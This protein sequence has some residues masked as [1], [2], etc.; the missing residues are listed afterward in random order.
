MYV[1]I[2]K[3]NEIP[4]YV[5]M[6]KSVGRANPLN[7]GGRGWLC[8]QTLEK[9][10]RNNVISEIHI[11][12]TVEEA[13]ALEIKL[14]EEFG[15]IQ[16]GTGPLTNLRAGGDGAHGMS[17]EGRERTRQRMLTNNP[18]K[19]EQVRK[20]LSARNSTPEALEKMTGGNNPAKQPAARKK[21]TALWQDPE[22]KER[23][24]K[25]RTGVQKHSAEEKE[26]RRQ[27]LLDPN[28]PMREYHKTLNTD[29]DIKAKRV[30][31]LRTREV[32]AK[33]SASLKAAWARRKGVII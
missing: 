4:F 16:L 15:R 3:H 6:T 33:I 25:L 20:K 1:Y 19:S 13:Q 14:I 27:K 26:K 30:A 2:W 31:T 28:N 21:L 23:Q 18:S 7:S 24:R 8:K 32:R 9:I 17:A 11:V 5:G 22:Y 12:P 10:G 29:P